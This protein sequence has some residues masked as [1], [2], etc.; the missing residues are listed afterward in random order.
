MMTF[1]DL[2]VTVTLLAILFTPIVLWLGWIEHR[3]S[4]RANHKTFRVEAA[5]RWW[6]WEDR[7]HTYGWPG[8]VH[9]PSDPSP[10]PRKRSI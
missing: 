9:N 3:E 6:L 1:D 7:M 10:R 4:W 5:C 8:T 2:Y